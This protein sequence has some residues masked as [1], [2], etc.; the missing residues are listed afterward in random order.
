MHPIFAANRPLIYFVYG[1]VFFVLGLAIALQSRRHSRLL[2]ARHLGWLAAFGLLHGLHEWGDLFI[3]IQQAGLPAPIYSMLLTLQLG[4]LAGSY[5]CLFQF[6]VGLLRP[7][8]PR[9]RW[10]RW[11]PRAVFLTWAIGTTALLTTTSISVVDWQV[12]SGILARYLMGLPGAGVAAVALYTRAPALITPLGLTRTRRML[13]LA[14]LALGGYAVMSGLVVPPASFF[15]ANQLNTRIVEDALGIPVP[16]Y[17]ALLGLGLT[18]A[19][20]QVLEVF[21]LE[22]DHRMDA[23][24]RR[25]ILASER[26]RI[27]R[28]LHDRMLQS[29]YAAGLVLAACRETVGAR[30]TAGAAAS[31]DAATLALEG[32]VDDIRGHIT[33][34]RSGPRA[35]NLAAGLRELPEIRALRSLADVAVEVDLPD[36]LTIDAD[37]IGHCLAV[38]GEAL[39]NTARHSQARHIRLRAD[40]GAGTIRIAVD[41]DGRGL[42]ADLIP[43][44]GLRDMHERARIVAG[45]LVLD[46]APGHGTRVTL[47]VP[48]A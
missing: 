46:S 25:Q 2:L 3:P 47:T 42:P 11:V 23:M 21:D 37:V 30:G 24:E 18:L 29:V 10:V 40:A 32:A 17:R 26:D 6:G 44:Y 5:A 8:A 16:V 4:L 15:P 34:L 48:L 7:L 38:A 19:F 39:S 9:W 36:D 41:D 45:S 22:I 13:R 33:E 20:I 43:G 12:T 27:G 1:L 28:D 31:L 35:V 14:A